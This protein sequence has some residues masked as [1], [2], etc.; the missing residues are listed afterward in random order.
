[1]IVG[2]RM[3]LRDR[4]YRISVVSDGLAVM[5]MTAVTVVVAVSV[6][7]GNG[8]GRMDVWAQVVAGGKAPAV[9]VTDGR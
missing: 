7:R 9:G 8:E 3:L 4:R 1:M 5:V 2:H 6:V